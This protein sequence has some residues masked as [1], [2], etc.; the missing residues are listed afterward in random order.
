MNAGIDRHGEV[1]HFERNVAVVAHHVAD[2]EEF[3]PPLEVLAAADR[4]VVPYA[5]SGLGNG[6]RLKQ[7]VGVGQTA[8]DAGILAVHMEDAALQCTRRLRSGLR[9]EPSCGTGRG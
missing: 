8:F 3:L 5:V 4:N 1:L 2:R 6:A 7:A 9:P